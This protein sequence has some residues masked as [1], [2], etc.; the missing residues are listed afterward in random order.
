MAKSNKGRKLFATTATAALVA[1]AIVPVASAA[2]INDFNSISSYAQEAVQDLNDRGV[3]KGDQKGN[4]NP[5]NPITRAEA[6]TILVGALELE[7]SGSTSFTDVKKSAWYYEAIDAAV[8]NGIFQG[9]GAGKFNPSANLT[10]SEAAIILVDAFG[11]EGSADLS[12]FKDSASVKSWA[13]EAL[14]IAV[15]NGVMKGDNGNLKPNAAIS[16]QDFAVM[17]HRTE[18]AEGTEEVSGSVKAINNTTVEVTFEDAVADLSALNF[19]I[20][21]LQITNKAVKQTDKKTVVLTTSAQTADVEYTVTVNNEAVGKFKGVTAVIPTA[22]KMLTPSVQGTIGKEVTVKAQ[23]EVP[24]GQSK[25]G[26]PV[27][28]NIVNGT[29]NQLNEK[30]EVVAYTNEEGIAS[31]SYT[32]Y[33]KYDDN[34]TAYASQKSSVFANAK[35]YWAQGLTVTEVTSGNTLANGSKKVYKIKTDTTVTETFGTAATSDDYN[36]VNVAFLENVNVAPDKLVRGVEVI[37]TGLITNAS[38]PSQV[39]TGGVQVVR[40]KVNANGEGSFTLTGSNGTVTPIVFVDESTN[41]VGKYTETALQSAAPAVKFELNHTLG[42]TVKA[43]GV[44]NAA[45]IN[46]NNDK[47]KGTGEGGRDYTVTITDKDGKVAPAGTVAHVTFQEGNY[48]TDKK[49]YILDAN[50][51]RVEVKKG[52]TQAIAVTGTKGEAT[53]TLVGNHD[54]YATPTVYLENGKE[55]GLDKAD[56]QVIGEGTY[57]VDAVIKDA[58]LKV[59]NADGKEV[60]TLPSSQVATFEYQSVDQN[61]FDYFAGTG[62]YEVSYQVTAQFADVTAGGKLVKAGTTETVK[63][64]AVNGKAELKVT[65]TNVASN[66]SV[67]AS[68]S[69]VSLPNQTATLA[70]TKGT[71]VPDVYTGLVSSINAVNNK[72]TFVGG[73]DPITYDTTAFKN[74]QG[75]TIDEA[76]FE[77]TIATALAAGSAVKVSAVKNADGKYVLE[78][79]SLTHANNIPV[80]VVSAVAVDSDRNGKA[81]Q[82]QLVFSKPVDAS[83]L[84]ALGADFSVTDGTV[85]NVVDGTANDNKVTLTL[86][87]EASDLSVGTL[88][89]TTKTAVAVDGAPLAAGTI[90]VVDASAQSAL[91]A[92]ISTAPGVVVDGAAANKQVLTVTATAATSTGNAIATVAG[93][94]FSKDI[95]FGVVAADTDAQVAQKLYNAVKD[96]ATVKAYYDVTYTAGANTVTFTNK[97]AGLGNAADKVTVANQFAAAIVSTVAAGADATKEVTTIANFTDAGAGATTGGKLE[98]TITRGGVVL[99]TVSIDVALG[100][101][102]AAATAQLYT[103]LYTDATVKA[104]YDVVYDGTNIKLTNKTAGVLAGTSNVTTSVTVTP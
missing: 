61:G 11:L 103:A 46:V 35:V 68:A 9:Q 2:Q 48:S 76:T 40:V 17:Y 98:A 16:R 25:A 70:F 37:D 30:I 47:N 81:D 57:F 3:I 33:Y 97:V 50:G 64:N 88:T 66:V 31:H 65:S 101:T 36:Y 14:S 95:H 89:I 49:A 5:K 18:A 93:N 19:A 8:S 71:Q 34:V 42:L 85:T 28:F 54:A 86:G 80:S 44:Q 29:V 83:K 21:G 100:T 74:E 82:V 87:T 79:E 20:E 1:S 6:A 75:I 7:G 73:F 10:R 99:K 102:G 77:S 63:V 27:T 78:I 12:E 92:G 91:V 90:N 72:L 23:V 4:F 32:R 38:Y 69:L 52:T 15:A 39:T 26:I 67:Q 94:G 56:L 55:V 84:T 13:E 41:R 96:D 53:F 59:L 24:A 104:Y 43:E 51:N 60:K 58:T 62:S 45:A 22:V